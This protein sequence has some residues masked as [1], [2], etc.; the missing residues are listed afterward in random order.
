MPP[1]LTKTSHIRSALLIGSLTWA[2]AATA[3]LDVSECEA[4]PF[5]CTV[6]L[7]G[8]IGHA[9]YVDL[10]RI[11]ETRPL[12]VL[13][14]ST[15]GSLHAAMQIGR[16]LRAREAAVSVLRNDRCL[17][18]CVMVLMG[19]P[20]R[21]VWGRVG[22]HR[23]FD[24]RPRA[25]SAKEAQREYE[26][27]LEDV[28]LFLREMNAS[29]RLLDAMM[30]VPP[31]KIRFLTGKELEEMGLG[32]T[33]PAFQARDDAKRAMQLNVSVAEYFV[34]KRRA[35]QQCGEHSTRNSFEEW[36]RCRASVLYAMP[37]EEV[38]RRM[39]RAGDAC[40]VLERPPSDEHLLECVLKEFWR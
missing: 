14:D 22:I 35:D 31:E 30:S 18:A 29:E 32:E 34:R 26:R 7:H 19:A 15:G 3:K 1:R 11:P 28:R 39:R 24:N 23:P 17:S 36:R 27:L 37:F 38:E 4:D 9:D 16:L 21:T 25:L 6:R 40:P 8:S 5:L 10:Q 2:C 33:D 20:Y 12:L 13:T